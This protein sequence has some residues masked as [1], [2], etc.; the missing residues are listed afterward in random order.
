M[1]EMF[2]M[3]IFIQS[4]FYVIKENLKIITHDNFEIKLILILYIFPISWLKKKNMAI[5]E[6]INN[7]SAIMEGSLKNNFVPIVD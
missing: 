3:I 5:I 2:C 7:S 1:I 4:I 6:L